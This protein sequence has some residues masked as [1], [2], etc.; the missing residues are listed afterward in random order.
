MLKKLLDIFTHLEQP[1][2][3]GIYVWWLTAAC[4]TGIFVI[5]MTR[6][7]TLAEHAVDDLA[8]IMTTVVCAYMGVEVIS[9][10]Q[11][12][13]RLAERIGRPP[14]SSAPPIEEEPPA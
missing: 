9:R 11:V 2:R 5:T 13:H 7:G 12:L 6:S 4:L 3:Q 10:S 8:A 14:A 1:A